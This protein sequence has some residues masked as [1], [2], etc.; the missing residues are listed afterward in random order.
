MFVT[1]CLILVLEKNDIYIYRSFLQDPPFVMLKSDHKKR[2]GNDRF[3]GF[4]I[5]L[6]YEIAQ[7][8]Q[9]QYE[10]YESPDGNYGAEV[11]EGEWNG[12]IREIIVGVGFV[13][14]CVVPP[15]FLPV[16]AKCLH[17]GAVLN[18]MIWKN[19]LCLELFSNVSDFRMLPCVWGQCLSRQT[20]NQWWI[21][22]TRTCRRHSGF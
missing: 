9:F 17:K 6:I 13:D 20:E 7:L 4:L 16:S 5:D 15:S 12:M 3:E 10:L 11:A 8:L 21:S 18:A 22:P 1:P 14:S 19:I 2:R